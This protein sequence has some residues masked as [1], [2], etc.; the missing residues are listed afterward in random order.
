MAPQVLSTLVNGF[1]SMESVK[2]SG[3][4]KSKQIDAQKDIALGE[5]KTTRFIAQQKAEK[6][7]AESVAAAQGATAYAGA[8]S[9]TANA[10]A[11][12][13]EAAYGALASSFESFAEGVTNVK[14]VVG[15]QKNEA[16]RILTEYASDAA[17]QESENLTKVLRE[18][19]KR[20]GMEHTMEKFRTL[21]KQKELK[22]DRE[23]NTKNAL[24]VSMF[25][26]SK[27]LVNTLAA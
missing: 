2:Q 17:A 23:Y 1:T 14:T 6:E 19:T 27:H 18:G 16:S 13:S 24:R 7:K 9:D 25:D 26:F 21:E 15:K 20:R 3:I 11:K 8:M 12:G 5:Q 22:A 10:A 4:I